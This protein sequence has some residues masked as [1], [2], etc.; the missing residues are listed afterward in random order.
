MAGRALLCKGDSSFLT[1]GGDMLRKR[2]S[3][4]RFQ[5]PLAMTR[6]LAVSTILGALAA[7]GP[8]Q[9]TVFIMDADRQLEAART[10]GAEG[11]SPYEW[12]SATL[13]LHQAR[14]EVGRSDYEVAQSHALRASRFANLARANAVAAV[15]VG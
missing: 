14:E 6:A 8:V 3:L 11:Y 15:K 4:P 13:Y 9:S 2:A 5:L 7:C 1:L 12:T 10:A